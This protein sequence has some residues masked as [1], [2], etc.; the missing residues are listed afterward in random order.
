MFNDQTL[1]SVVL[2]TEDA[3]DEDVFNTF[4][5]ITEQTHRKIDIIISTFREDI[6]ELKEKCAKLH[7]DVRW[8]QHSPGKDFLSE[9]LTLADGELFFYK[10]VNNCLWYPR[11]IQS[12]I[13]SFNKDTG[14]KWALSHVEKRNIDQ[15]ESPYNTLSFRIDN[16][17]H[18]DN[19][20]LDEICHYKELSVDWG[21]CLVQKDDIPLFYPG[22]AVKQWIED[23]ARGTI[24]AEI[25]VIQWEK[26]GGAGPN[27]KELED[28]YKQVGVPATTE[29][30]EEPVETD[31]GIEI[32]RIL[33]TVVGNKHFDEY[34]DSIREVISQTEDISS[35]AVKRTIGMGDIVLMEPIIRKLKEKYPTSKI[36]FYTAKSDVIKYFETQPDEIVT[37]DETDVVKDSLE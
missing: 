7:L 34:S 6:D 2:I 19:I 37:I 33:P 3:S 30:K 31:E 21:A 18:P 35:I 32:K 24:P 14:T 15:P 20:T 8:A 1:V 10:T 4:K 11:H 26:A 36:T 28:F 9:V 25:T 23:K 29:I 5:N 12:H 16:P 13:E 22:Y 17:P 27:E